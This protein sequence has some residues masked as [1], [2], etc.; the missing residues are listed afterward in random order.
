MKIE[1]KTETIPTPKM[2]DSQGT[3]YPVKCIVRS[4]RQQMA[5][6]A[7]TDWIVESRAFMCGQEP[8]NPQ[9]DG[10]YELVNQGI[11]IRPGR[12]VQPNP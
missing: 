4:M 6:G 8:V 11:R 12:E 9:P 7:W 5:D 1:R 2:R 10:S 3:V